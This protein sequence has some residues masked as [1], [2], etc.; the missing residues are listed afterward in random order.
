MHRADWLWTG[1]RRRIA[2]A[3]TATV[4]IVA[5]L[6]PALFFSGTGH[7]AVWEATE[8]WSPEWESRY[9]DWVAAHWGEGAAHDPEDE[10]LFGLEFDCADAVYAMRIVFAYRHK[11]PFA[12][13]DPRRAGQLLSNDSA[14][15]DALVQE[16]AVEDDATGEIRLEKGE[17][18]TETQKLRQFIDDVNTWTTTRN[19]ANDTF[20][21]PLSGVR[22]GDIYLSPGEHAF[23][24]K[25]VGDNGAITTVSA[26]LPRAWRPMAEVADFPSYVPTD[27][28]HRDGYRRFK[29]IAH[30]RTASANV[31]GASLDQWEIAARLD[32]DWSAFAL[33]TQDALSRT[34][35]TPSERVTRR[36]TALCAYARERVHYV[37]EAIE[38]LDRMAQEGRRC[39]T[40]NEYGDFSTPTRDKRLRGMFL[41]LR[42]EMAISDWRLVR[43]DLAQDVGA[44]FSP[45][46]YPRSRE[47]KL[48]V[49]AVE[50]D[51]LEGTTLT[52]DQLWQNLEA[53]LVISDPHATRPYRWGLIDG[54]ETECRPG[55]A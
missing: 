52:L 15:W 31:P 46:L 30:L 27:K 39:M 36:L 19:L 20:P 25:A 53:E 44:I 42:A 5:A 24:V 26:S 4:A 35:E 17:R 48:E 7:A 41:T 14:E 9:V 11:L 18:L 1:A 2:C 16:L 28:R 45:S 55:G 50:L 6:M 21:V 47:E 10:V 12:I 8:S 23:I 13:N 32:E 33:A 43:P 29:P 38:Q 22:P 3:R 49:C 51:Y 34:K 54:W 37:D 40:I